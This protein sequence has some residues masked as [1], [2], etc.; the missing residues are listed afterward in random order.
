MSDITKI[1]H[2]ASQKQNQTRNSRGTLCREEVQQMQST[3]LNYDWTSSGSTKSGKPV[4]DWLYG[5]IWQSTTWWDNQTT[6]TV[7][8]RWKRSMIDQKH[9]LG[10]DSSNAGWWRNQLIKK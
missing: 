1:H 5:G 8:D 2:D 3:L 10:T 6:N 9:V 7:E 4:L